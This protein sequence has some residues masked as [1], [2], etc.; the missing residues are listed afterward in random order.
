M[1]VPCCNSKARFLRRWTASGR[2]TAR[3]KFHSAVLP[4]SLS[5]R[6]A[7]CPGGHCEKWAPGR[8]SVAGAN[9][10]YAKASWAVHKRMAVFGGRFQVLRSPSCF[11]Q[12]CSRC[13]AAEPAQL[14]CWPQ[15]PGCARNT[16]RSDQLSF[17][18]YA[19]K[20]AQEQ[21]PEG[22]P[23]TAS[24]ALAVSL[25]HYTRLYTRQAVQQWV[26][27]GSKRSGPGM[28][29]G[30]AIAPPQLPPSPQM[31]RTKMSSD[32]RHQSLCR[33]ELEHLPPF[34]PAPASVD[35]VTTL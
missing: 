21:V 35:G 31:R 33:L 32:C 12:P 7:A 18:A 14:P 2:T 28:F 16:S 22:S 13:G 20:A 11:C 29:A 8:V 24:L 5:C 9:T 34:S 15:R 17:G 19:A 1:G 23:E 4:P 26:G 10:T 6:N 3:F 30:A 27:Q 25:N